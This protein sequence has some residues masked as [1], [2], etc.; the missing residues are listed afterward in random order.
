MVPM[1]TSL[2]GFSQHAAVGTSSAAVASTGLS[3]CLS[4]ASSGKVDFV[5]AA[6]IAS[7][8]ML[9]ARFGAKFTNRFNATQLQRAFA[10]FQLAVAPLVPIKGFLVRASKAEDAPALDVDAAAAQDASSAARTAQLVTLAAIGSVAGVASGMFGIG[11]GVVITPALCITTDMAHA[12]VLGTTLA[13]MV[14]P[15]IVSAVTH[16]RMGNVSVAAVLPLCLGSAIGAYAGGQLAVHAPS[17]EPLQ[18]MFAVVIAGMGGQKL[19]ALRG[20]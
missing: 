1:M 12:A 16:H 17:E 9:G 14:P 10:I 11:G 4:F 19:W 7:T 2:A 15:G 6:A 18:I 8:A 13:S 20:K 3:G 5:A